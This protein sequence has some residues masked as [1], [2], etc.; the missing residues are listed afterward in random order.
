[1]EKTHGPGSTNE[2]VKEIIHH[3]SLYMCVF[4]HILVLY[5][6]LYGLTFG[7]LFLCILTRG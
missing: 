3:V 1:M 6:K 4:M 2:A 7:V 5:C